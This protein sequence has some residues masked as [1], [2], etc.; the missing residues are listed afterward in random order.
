MH[1]A[2]VVSP[3]GSVFN[4][5]AGAS[6]DQF[7]AP[8]DEPFSAIS[9]SATDRKRNNALSVSLKQGTAEPTNPKSIKL[10]CAFSTSHWLNWP[11][12]RSRST[13]GHCFGLLCTARCG[14]FSYQA[15]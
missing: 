9:L 2:T 3:I 6:G 10:S 8:Q 14:V 15:S 5:G 1:W 13:S 4:L 11:L 7:P 12:P